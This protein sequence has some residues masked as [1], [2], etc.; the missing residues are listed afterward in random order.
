MS[1]SIESGPSKSIKGR[2]RVESGQLKLTEKQAQG[3]EIVVGPDAVLT[4]VHENGSM[5]TTGGIKGTAN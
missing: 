2:I 3:L 5:T 1:N 4:V